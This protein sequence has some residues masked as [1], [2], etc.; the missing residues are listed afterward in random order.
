MQQRKRKVEDDKAWEGSS[1]PSS[2]SP[3]HS[4]PSSL[5]E[6]RETRVGSWRNFSSGTNPAKKQK[7]D[8]KKKK[9]VILG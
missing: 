4:Q 1:F 8:K 2:Q 7:T 3:G 9:S 6:G 5:A